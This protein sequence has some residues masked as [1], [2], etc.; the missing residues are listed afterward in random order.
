[1]MLCWQCG[2]EVPASAQTCP[3]CDAELGESPRLRVSRGEVRCPACGCVWEQE[4]EVCPECG[5]SPLDDT[6]GPDEDE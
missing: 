1:M 2:A 5:A 3:E 4:E 6:P